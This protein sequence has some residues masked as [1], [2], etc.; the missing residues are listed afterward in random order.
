M[1]SIQFRQRAAELRDSV[2]ARR[3]LVVDPEDAVFVTV[4]RHRFAVR[5]QITVEG[6]E[7]IER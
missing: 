5:F 1:M 6:P 7:V 3:I 2:T 4:Q